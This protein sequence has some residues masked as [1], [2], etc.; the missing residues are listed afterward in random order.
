MSV[1][2]DTPGVFERQIKNSL[3]L[4]NKPIN[5]GTKEDEGF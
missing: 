3:N 5:L 2:L 1:R 4:N